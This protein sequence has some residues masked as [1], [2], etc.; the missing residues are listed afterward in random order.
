MRR[1]IPFV[2]KTKCLYCSYWIHQYWYDGY[3][4]P[5]RR[6]TVCHYCTATLISGG[7]VQ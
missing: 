2:A 3:A 4:G 6:N 7:S 1:G 5:R